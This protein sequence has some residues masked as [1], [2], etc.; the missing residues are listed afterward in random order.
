MATEA[1]HHT[2]FG[3]LRTVP[4]N[5]QCKVPPITLWHLK[6]IEF[7]HLIQGDMTVSEHARKFVELSRYSPESMMDEGRKTSTFEW[8][9]RHEIRQQ[10]Y[11]FE[12]SIYSAV[13]AK[14][15]LIKGTSTSFLQQW[16]IPS[17]RFHI[18]GQC[19]LHRFSRTR[20]LGP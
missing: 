8:H 4:S 13:L 11:V 5:F 18:N 19:L 17:S 3:H 12:L 7:A 20:D 15:Q 16:A 6:E 14:T 1:D 9:L 10:L 2:H